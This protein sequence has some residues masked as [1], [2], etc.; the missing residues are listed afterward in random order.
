MGAERVIGASHR[1]GSRCSG[2]MSS[3]RRGALPSKRHLPLYR[4]FNCLWPKIKV[5]PENH[6]DSFT[7]CFSPR[8]ERFAL[9]LKRPTNQLICGLF[10]QRRAY[11]PKELKVQIFRSIEVSDLDTRIGA[12]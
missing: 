10:P 6:H 1:E 12:L 3:A 9:E 2:L 8:S 5:G 7:D 11:D 4:E